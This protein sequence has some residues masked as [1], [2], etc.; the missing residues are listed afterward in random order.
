[1]GPHPLHQEGREEGE[2]E[3][4]Q[5]GGGEESRAVGI[6]LS[7]ISGEQRKDGMAGTGHAACVAPADKKVL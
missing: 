7:G 6:S 1:M 5:D 2:E 4:E 3:G